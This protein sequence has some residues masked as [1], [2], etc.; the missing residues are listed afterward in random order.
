MRSAASEREGDGGASL[1]DEVEGLRR[2]LQG[3]RI[4]KVATWHAPEDQW[5][6]ARA[7]FEEKWN[8]WTARARALQRSLAE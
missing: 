1:R 3:L 2:E 6:H 7:H 5:E 4:M 8:E